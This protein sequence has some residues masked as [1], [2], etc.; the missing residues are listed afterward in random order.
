MS[1]TK[2]GSHEFLVQPQTG[3]L[4]LLSVTFLASS[5]RHTSQASIDI[6]KRCSGCLNKIYIQY[7]PMLITKITLTALEYETEI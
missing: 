3:L 1:N 5:P 7:R 6:K 4:S 2:W